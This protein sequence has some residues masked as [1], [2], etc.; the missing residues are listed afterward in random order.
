LE[1]ICGISEMV[2]PTG[3]TSNHRFEGVSAESRVRDFESSEQGSNLTESKMEMVHPTGFTSNHRF[4]GVSAESRV[5]DFES[6]EQGS[7]LT[8]SKM[9]MVHPTGFE[10]V[11]PG[12]VDRCLI[13]FGHGCK[14]AR[15][16]WKNG[17]DLNPLSQPF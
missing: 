11:I 13:Q 3:F 7:N 1:L 4:E 9:E 6:S 17:P 5:R 8:E 15:I 2:H 12:F 14:R 16:I 10:P